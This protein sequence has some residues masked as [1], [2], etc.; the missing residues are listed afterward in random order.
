VRCASGQ[1]SEPST[2]SL[3]LRSKTH[4]TDNPTVLFS[5]EVDLYVLNCCAREV[6]IQGRFKF[7][8]TA[9]RLGKVVIGAKAPVQHSLQGDELWRRAGSNGDESWR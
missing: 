6:V 4:S 8:E 3:E 7:G 5:A 9:F 1:W 2:K